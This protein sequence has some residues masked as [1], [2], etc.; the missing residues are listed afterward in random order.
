MEIILILVVISI[1]VYVVYQSSPS[2]KLNKAKVIMSRGNYSQAEDILEKIFNKHQDAPIALANCKLQQGLQAISKNETLALSYFNQMI[3]LEKRFPSKSDSNLF[4][5]F[6]ARSLFEI[7]KIKF[8]NALKQSILED[9]I[10]KLSENVHFIDTSIT[11][12]IDKEF[13]ELKINHLSKL[14]E[15]YCL[16]GIKSEKQ[17]NF[18]Q[19]ENLFINAKEYGLQAR[20]NVAIANSL[21]RLAI[22]K[23]KNNEDPLDINL[24]G[25]TKAEDRYISDFYFRYALKLLHLKKFSEVEEIISTNLPSSNMEVQKIKELIHAEKVRNS[26]KQ[27]DK[28]NKLLDQLYEKSFPI[29]EVKA[30]YEK[31]DSQIEDLK[32]VLPNHYEKLKQ[33]KPSLFNRLLSHSISEHQFAGA[34]K[35]IQKFPSFWEN[36]EL[37]Q[38]LSICCYNFVNQGNLTEKNYKTIVSSWLTAVHSPHVILKSI[39][40]T[41]WDDDYSFTLQNALGFNN[42]LD[43]LPHNVNYEEPTETNISIEVAQRELI[44]QFEALLHDKIEDVSLKTC[45]KE[46]YNTEK[47]AIGKISSIIQKDMLFAGPYFSKMCGINKDIISELDNDYL[48]Y[49]DENSL[50]AGI[51]YLH[52]ESDSLVYE[53]SSGRDLI[54]KII[55]AIEEEDVDVIDNCLSD[56]SILTNYETLDKMFEDSVFNKIAS[57]IEEDDE[58]TD[59]IPIMGKCIQS[60]NKNDRLKYQYSNFVSNYCIS[61]VN[62]DEMDYFEALTKMVPAYL[63]SPDNP[64]ICKNI[65]TLIRFNVMDLLNRKNNKVLFLELIPLLDRIYPKRSKTFIQSSS[66]LAKT[67]RDL[68]SQLKTAGVNTYFIDDTNPLAKD[69]WVVQDRLTAEGMILRSAITQLRRLSEA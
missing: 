35:L 24:N 49:G 19:A 59:L 50:I 55:Q 22:C 17:A 66:E 40:T 23:L 39:E 28:I 45:S 4:Q 13:S 51:P 26:A 42:Q 56:F 2:T 68:L 63:Y 6:K 47:E 58:N 34:I 61:K 5:Q 16:I 8:E 64:K 3:D 57:K 41:E 48:E 27:I 54:N 10:S 14:S 11:V 1:I 52:N 12:G 46:F 20:N 9:Q 21:A 33:I 43:G 67:R 30:F 25:F 53:Y 37:L 15:L 7:S 31:I 69:D 36:P 18:K 38:N 29:D 44:N 62:G 32:Q 65:V 60:S